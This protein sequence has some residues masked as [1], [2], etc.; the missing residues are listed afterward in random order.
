MAKLQKENTATFDFLEGQIETEAGPGV[1]GFYDGPYYSFYCWPPTGSEKDELSIAEALEDLHAKL[2]EDGPFDGLLGFS[3]GGTLIAEFL[4]EYTNRMPMTDPPIRCAV[5]ICSF[6]PFR[7]DENEEPTFK[8]STLKSLQGIP[9]L[10]ITG[11]NDFAC[12]Y[13]LDLH[14]CF[15]PEYATLVTHE[16]GH[17]IPHDEKTLHRIVA[18]FRDLHAR[19]SFGL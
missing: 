15:K 6:P 17:E 5:F 7:M 14:K 11:R 16:G 19:I 1:G 8:G 2:E 10:H 3:H 9:T 18:A 13:S 4:S 12:K